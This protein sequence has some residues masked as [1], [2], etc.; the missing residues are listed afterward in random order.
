[1]VPVKCGSMTGGQLVSWAAACY[2]RPAQRY[3]LEMKLCSSVPEI[4]LDRLSDPE[5]QQACPAI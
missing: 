1:M 2:H 4:G 3:G 5:D